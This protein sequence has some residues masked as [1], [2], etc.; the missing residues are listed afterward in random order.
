MWVR[1][2]PPAPKNKDCVATQFFFAFG[3]SPNFW[4]PH[5]STYGNFLGKGKTEQIGD[6]ICI[7]ANLSIL[8][9]F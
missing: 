6:T 4:G 1:L 5:K 7:Y 8:R 3:I 9:E 2:P